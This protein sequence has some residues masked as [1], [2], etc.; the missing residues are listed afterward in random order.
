MKKLTLI[1]GAVA[2]FALLLAGCSLFGGPDVI[3]GRWQQVSV[4]GV[5]TVV[6]AIVVQFTD[7]TYNGTT[8]G[9]ATNTGIWT[10]SGSSYT[11][12]GVFFGFVASS[13]TI[14][15]SFTNSNNTMTY[16]DSSGYA[17]VYNRQ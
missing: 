13:S 12:N 9:V 4:N 11:L 10:K 14:N 15:P 3:V 17:E 5:P 8:A 2:L 7:Y 6:L 1:I 16:T